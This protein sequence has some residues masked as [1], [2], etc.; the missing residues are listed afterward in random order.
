MLDLLEKRPDAI[1]VYRK[2]A[3]MNSSRS[4][5]HDQFGLAYRPSEYARERIETPF[6]RVES[7]EKD[8]MDPRR[9]CHNHR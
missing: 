7:R 9:N 3:A 6:V 8:R 5:R 4:M 2:A 1:S